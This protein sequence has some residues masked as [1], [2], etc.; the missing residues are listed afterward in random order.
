MILVYHLAS[1]IN[2]E[3]QILELFIFIIGIEE[4]LMQRLISELLLILK[5][6]NT[7]KQLQ[8]AR[9]PLRLIRITPRLIVDMDWFYMI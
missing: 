5:S 4:L 9:N 8:I 7:T 1:N 6:I 2:T 3:L